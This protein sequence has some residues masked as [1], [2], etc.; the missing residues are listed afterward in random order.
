[1][2]DGAVL[3]G[4]KASMTLATIAYRSSESGIAYRM[5]SSVTAR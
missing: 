5:A 1:M 2:G 4:G 3:P